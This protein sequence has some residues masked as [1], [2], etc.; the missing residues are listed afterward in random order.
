VFARY[1]WPFAKTVVTTLDPSE[2]PQFTQSRV[3]TVKWLKTVVIAA[4]VL[5]LTVFLAGVYYLRV[6]ATSNAAALVERAARVSEE[7]ALKMFETNSVILN[8][9]SDLLGD[10]SN[11]ELQARESTLHAQLRRM[12]SGLPQMQGVFVIDSTGR[13][14]VTD[15]RFPTRRDIDFSDRPSFVHHRGNGPQPYVSELLTSRTTGEPFF[16]ISLRRT[17]ADGEFGGTMST[18]LSPAYFL[19]FYRDLSG[20]DPELKIALV[21]SGGA[22]LVRWPEQPTPGDAPGA[23]ASRI[24]LDVDAAGAPRAAKARLPDGS[25]G[26]LVVRPLGGFPVSVAAWMDDGAIR[27]VWLRQS[28]LLTALMVPVTVGL[29]LSAGVAL[30]KARRSLEAA[31]ALR[32][33]VRQRQQVEETLRQAQKLEAMGRLTGG[34]AHDFNN[35]LM[36]VSNNLFIVSRKHP[37]LQGS[38]VMTSMERAVASGAK[39]TRQLLSFSRR[40]PFRP[41]SIHLQEA[42]PPILDLIRPATGSSVVVSGSVAPDTEYIE[43]DAAELELALLNLAINAKDAMPGGGKVSIDVGN[44]APAELPSGLSGPTVRITVSDTGEGIEPQLLERVFE[45]FFTTKPAGHGTGLGLS[46]VYGFCQRAGGTARVDS[47]VGVG[48]H[49]HLYLPA[50]PPKAADVRSRDASAEAELSLRVLVAEDNPEVASA[51]V[52]VLELLGCT[53][54]HASSGDEAL[55][56]L[57]AHADL[58]DLLLSDIVMP[59][60]L[61]G[62]ALARHVQKAFPRLPVLLMSGYSQQAAEA[63]SLSLDVV[64][65]PC[66]PE[67]LA[68]A[69]RR[70]YARR[71]R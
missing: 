69:I 16:D 42:L 17:R 45:P 15:R 21:R 38:R 4:A 59:G 43:V 58:Y 28:A 31:E 25:H 49:V 39:L 51:T 11:E 9:I 70:A 19:A 62:V 65:K 52:A 18:S 66:T 53:V 61:N 54:Q 68:T 27:A 13:M 29:V 2:V 14:L 50:R 22:V 46:Q 40:Q 64:P 10:A 60:T 24:P 48:T 23:A 55:Q 30:S 5:P 1:A 35:L 26:L 63:G 33:E 12:S 41:E 32:T 37:E 7:H 44:A 6:Q 56:L 3:D 71:Q 36:I 47:Q 20:N 34:V 57:E 8:R 67:V